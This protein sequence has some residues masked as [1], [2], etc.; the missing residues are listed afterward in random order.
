MCRRVKG[1]ELGRFARDVVG[2]L[3]GK[4]TAVASRINAGMQ[5][6]I[7]GMDLLNPTARASFQRLAA[8]ESSSGAADTT[9]STGAASKAPDP[10]TMARDAIAQGAP[11][12][13]VIKRLQQ[14]GIDPSRLL[15]AFPPA[16][17]NTPGQD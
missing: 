9:A 4:L 16:L 15:T 13:A 11:R 5:T 14:N 6:N 12:D 1:K 2:L 3:Q 10:L 7:T 17:D 8:P